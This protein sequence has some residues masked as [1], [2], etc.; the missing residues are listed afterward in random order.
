MT[1]NKI[2]AE[3]QITGKLS[4]EGKAVGYTR[5]VVYTLPPTA[6]C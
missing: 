6:L 4:S 2:T 3:E 1:N 5:V